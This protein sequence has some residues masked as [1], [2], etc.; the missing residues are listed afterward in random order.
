MKL[1][2]LLGDMQGGNQGSSTFG[3]RTV[4][5]IGGHRPENQAGYGNWIER[6]SLAEPFGG[7]PVA[8]L[9]PRLRFP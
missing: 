4:N 8:C 6:A 7:L 5:T 9:R 2:E 1:F 3:E